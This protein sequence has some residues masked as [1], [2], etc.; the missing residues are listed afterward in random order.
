MPAGAAPKLAIKWRAPRLS[1]FALQLNTPKRRT[2]GEHQVRLALQS[3]PDL[4]RHTVIMNLHEKLVEKIRE[5]IF[6]K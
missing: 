4:L 2:G 3:Y 1:A 5:N 6:R